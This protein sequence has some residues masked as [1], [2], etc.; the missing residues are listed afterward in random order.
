MKLMLLGKDGQ[1]GQAL[2]PVLA[3]LGKVWALGKTDRLP[4]ACGDLLLPQFVAASIRRYRPDVVI[5]AAAYTAVDRAE[6]ESMLA[7]AINHQA[8]Y[9]IAE[10]CGEV[11]ALLVHYSSNYVFDGKQSAAYRETDSVAPLSIYG[12]SKAA[13]EVAIRQSGAAY[14]IIRTAW[15][16]SPYA[17]CFPNMMQTLAQEKERLWMIADQVGTPT[18]V[19]WLA[20]Q[21][22]IMLAAVHRQAKLGGTYHLTAQGETTWYDYASLIVQ[23][24]VQQGA[25]LKL[26][27][28]EPIS[29]E[30]YGAAAC[31]PK[32]GRLACDKAMS[33][34]G[35]V[36]PPWQE[37]VICQLKEQ[38]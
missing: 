8:L 7:D 32:Q 14:L 4:E 27:Q 33:A 15:L 10:A 30:D 37:G 13:G 3:A 9:P 2:R 21:S 28:L 1:L 34:F 36:L 25:N 22:A 35:L 31:R 19:Q 18:S 24:L 29:S 38:A 16:Y 11:G 17:P 6:Q 5:N 20:K 12:Q 26:C 23:T